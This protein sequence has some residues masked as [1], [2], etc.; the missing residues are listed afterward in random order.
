[1][2][3]RKADTV[4]GTLHASE[5]SGYTKDIAPERV[6]T[7]PIERGARAIPVASLSGRQEG[8]P[9]PAE[10]KYHAGVHEVVDATEAM[11][12]MKARKTG[13]LPIIPGGLDDIRQQKRGNAMRA[14]PLPQPDPD[15][16]IIE[17]Q[18]GD[19]DA[20]EPGDRVPAPRPAVY[21]RTERFTPQAEVP[22]GRMYVT[23]DPTSDYLKQRKRVHI[24]LAESEINVSAIDV[25]RTRYSV[26]ILLPF[27]QDDGTFVPKPGSEVTINT[28]S[29]SIPCYFPGTYFEIPKLRVVGLSFIR[30]EEENDRP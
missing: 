30:K 13:K 16:T 22:E 23:P 18:P 24:E 12:R 10:R 26:T 3:M 2:R 17:T 20:F 7:S 14:V 4:P 5:R 6:G 28:E 1:M 25:I 29:E 9:T 21:G 11:N 15:E 27:N 8:I 19:Y